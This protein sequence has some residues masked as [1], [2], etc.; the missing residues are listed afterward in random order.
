MNKQNNNI[1]VRETEYYFNDGNDPD[2]VQKTIG[3]WIMVTNH[4]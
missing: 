1:V 3:C 2:L 4:K